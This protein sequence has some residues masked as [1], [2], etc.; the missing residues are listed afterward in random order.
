MKHREPFHHPAPESRAAPLKF[1]GVGGG[2]GGVS[3]CLTGAQA[4]PPSREQGPPAHQVCRGCSSRK[5]GEDKTDAGRRRDGQTPIR[6]HSKR[7]NHR[8]T[9]ESGDFYSER[10]RSPI[11]AV[12]TGPPG[13]LIF[14]QTFRQTTLPSSVPHGSPSTVAAGTP[15]CPVPLDF[16]PHDWV[17]SPLPVVTCTVTE[18]MS[19]L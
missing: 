10:L 16:R 8:H 17:T 11:L 13:L 12:N 1:P 9:A 6:Q 15:V 19:S 4:P 14:T 18:R 5:T 3:G 2:R 7:T